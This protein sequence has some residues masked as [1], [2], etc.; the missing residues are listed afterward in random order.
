MNTLFSLAFAGGSK[1]SLDREEKRINYE[2]SN[3]GGV[4]STVGGKRPACMPGVKPGCGFVNPGLL[5][6][7]C[8]GKG[9]MA[10]KLAG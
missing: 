8:S 10:D 6:S 2:K 9:C 4:L 3:G 5:Q 7:P 1:R